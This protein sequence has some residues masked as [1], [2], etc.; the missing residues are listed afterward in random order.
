MSK[1]REKGKDH[2]ADAEE[3]DH[4]VRFGTLRL[5]NPKSWLELSRWRLAMRAPEWLGCG[6]Y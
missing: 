2:S 6:S 1:R 4:Q 5:R 3:L